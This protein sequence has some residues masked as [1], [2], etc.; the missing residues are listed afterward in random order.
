MKISFRLQTFWAR[1]SIT[2]P[3]P[4]VVLSVILLA[5]VVLV[6]IAVR[7]VFGVMAAGV[8]V[9][10]EFLLLAV[11]VLVVR[12]MESFGRMSLLVASLLTVFGVFGTSGSCVNGNLG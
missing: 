2:F 5:T 4:V 3:V 8:V 12:V 7:P 10:V 11:L 9:V 6:M 1:F